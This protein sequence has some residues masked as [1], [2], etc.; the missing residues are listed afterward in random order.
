MNTV[1]HI[2]LAVVVSISSQN[3]S[4]PT[5]NKECAKLKEECSNEATCCLGLV[6]INLTP[7]GTL[8]QH[9]CDLED[10]ALRALKIKI[11]GTKNV[12]INVNAHHSENVDIDVDSSS[13]RPRRDRR[14]RKK[15][16]PSQAFNTTTEFAA[17]QRIPTAQGGGRRTQTYI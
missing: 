14:L 13:K 10:L 7:N 1:L 11:R 12:D 17:A 5:V 15:K 9:H 3:I 6:C 2:L 16:Q 8:A 4:D